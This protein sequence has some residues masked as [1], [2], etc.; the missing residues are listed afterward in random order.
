MRQY[1]QQVGEWLSLPN[2]PRLP[3]LS[4][5]S[6]SATGLGAAGG[7][8]CRWDGAVRLGSHSA[9]GFVLLNEAGA[10]IWAA[11]VQFPLLEDPMVAE[12]LTLR[13]A[14]R[15]C[16]GGVLCLCDLKGTPK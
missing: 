13:E 15:W 8:V 2:D 9:G 4:P 12:I 11:G 16:I 5:P 14:I 6:T 3:S 10:I 1:H 7:P